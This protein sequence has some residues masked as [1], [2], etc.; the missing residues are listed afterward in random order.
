[1]WE[2]ARLYP[3]QGFWT[4]ED[5]LKLDGTQNMLVEYTDGFVEV[6]PRPTSCTSALSSTWLR[7]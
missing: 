4:E 2:L 7:Y 1:V 5:Y 6:L 3:A